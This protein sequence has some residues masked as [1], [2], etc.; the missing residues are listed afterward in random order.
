MQTW[1]YIL[2]FLAPM[3]AGISVYIFKKATTQQINLLLAFSGAY[4]FS[5]TVLHLLPEVYHTN[6]HIIGLYVLIGF[7]IQILLEQFSKGIEHGHIHPPEN[8]KTAFNIS[9]IFGLS[10]HAFMEGIPLAGNY[11]ISSSANPLLYGIVM[12]KIPAAFALMCVLTHTTSKKLHAVLLLM[13]FSMMSP[14]ALMLAENNYIN[15]LLGLSGFFDIILAIIIGSFLHISTTILFES[16][17]RIH[18]FS[19]L[20]II[21]IIVGAGI[22]LLTL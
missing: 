11:E 22:A 17:T 13:F 21:A 19:I 6:D 5:I 1:Q 20:K 12:H 9:I 15:Q 4:L 16:S 3:L 14:L 2:L 7:F 10:A 18:K 8:P